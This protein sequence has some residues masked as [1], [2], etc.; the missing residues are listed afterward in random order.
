MQK[1][2]DLPEFNLPVHVMRS[3]FKLWLKSLMV[4]FLH[5]EITKRVFIS[6]RYIS[7]KLTEFS[8]HFILTHIS[9]HDNHVNYL[10]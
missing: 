1:G 8:L 5:T 9:M 2:E 4:A 6:L 3:W 10:N 7:T